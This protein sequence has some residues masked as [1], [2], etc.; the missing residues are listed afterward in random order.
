M[1]NQI[2]LISFIVFILSINSLYGQKYE[3]KH[4]RFNGKGFF[5]GTLDHHPSGWILGAGATYLFTIPDSIEK[6]INNDDYLFL[7]SS[8]LALYAE[9][10]RYKLFKFAPFF[11]YLDY[12]LAYTRYSAKE[13]V[14]QQNSF[15]TNT[16][17]DQHA[18]AFFN[19]SNIIE[20]SNPFFIQN[21]F[22]VNVNYAFSKNRSASMG[23]NEEFPSPILAQIHYKLSFGLL[24]SKRLMILP[25]VRIPLVS[26]WPFQAPIPKVNYFNSDYYPVAFSL[27]FVFLQKPKADCPPVFAPGTLDG[28]GIPTDIR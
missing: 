25:S 1:K 9:V 5:P 15:T 13:E 6:N 7:P 28:E 12:G 19:I 8:K 16:L 3:L 18:S 21:S 26:A 11:K 23:L 24:A 22:G 27:R 14:H 10:G 4:Q 20:V 17:I 2:T